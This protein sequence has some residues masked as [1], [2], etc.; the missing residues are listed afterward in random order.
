[1]IEVVVK[2]RALIAL[3][4][5]CPTLCIAQ[6]ALTLHYP[7][8][9]NVWTEAL[10]IGNGRLGAMLFGGVNEDLIQLNEATLWSGGPVADNVN[11]KAYEFLAPARAALKRGEYGRASDLLRRMQGPY[12]QSY[13]PLGDLVIQQDTGH[14]SSAGYRRELNIRSG[15]ASDTFSVDGVRYQREVFAS[16]PPNSPWTG[17]KQ[18]PRA[19]W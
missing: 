3:L 16:A 5:L 17:Y 10:P 1:M 2:I 8:P 15:L 13:L 14:G 11:P 4:L 7:K 12:T 18:M 19:T 6:Q 9:A